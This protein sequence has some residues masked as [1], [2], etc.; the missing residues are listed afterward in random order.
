MYT[1]ATVIACLAPLLGFR[2]SPEGSPDAPQLADALLI[3]DG[4]VAVQDVHPLLTIQNIAQAAPEVPAAGADTA[5]QFSAYLDQARRAAA[6][7]VVEAFAARK[8]LTGAG[9]T[10]L[11]DTQ[12]TGQSGTYRRKVIKQGRFV[13]LALRQVSGTDVAVSI[14]GL[15][16]QFT[17][18]NPDFRLYLYHS[19][20]A[21][22][23]ATFDVP[24]NQTVYFE[25]TPLTIPLPAGLDRG[26]YRLGYFEDDLVGQAIDLEADFSR[27]PCQSCNDDY[28]YFD[29]WAPMV[30][31]RAFTAE[32]AADTDE[33]P[34]DG[35]VSYV[36]GSNFGLNLKLSAVCDLSSYFCAHK[37]LFAEALRLQL[38]CD[39][40]S[41]MANTTRNNGVSA[42]VQKLALL[43]L[44]NRPDYQ[45]GMLSR[46]TTALEAL[47][48]DLSGVSRPCLPCAPKSGVRVGAI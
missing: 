24:R 11:A 34:G 27:R 46:L 17:E 40:L 7:K 2:Q 47:D 18:V 4:G 6:G 1:P 13:G 44:N 22:P 14:T 23:V 35:S 31:V 15:G 32:A 45:P 28:K 3:A 36:T 25:W 5:A 19:S 33:L 20:S 10:V 8:K 48:V 21:L 38:G 41:L 9:K 26:E 16:T 43:E 12:L 37:A 30:Q 39:L 29:K 42:Q